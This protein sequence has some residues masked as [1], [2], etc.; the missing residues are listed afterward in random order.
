MGKKTPKTAPSPW[1]SVT[2]PEED[3]A[4]TIDNMHKKFGKDRMCGSRDMRA[5]RQMH[6]QTDIDTSPPLMR[7]K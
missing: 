5:D 3:Q 7:A 4:T 6:R 2:L 1:D